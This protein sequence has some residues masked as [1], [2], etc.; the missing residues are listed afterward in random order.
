[1]SRIRQPDK[2]EEPAPAE[3]LG[4]PPGPWYDEVRDQ[5][6]VQWDQESQT[7][8]ATS[9]DAARNIARQ[10]GQMWTKVF[11]PPV[12]RDDSVQIHGGGSARNIVYADPNEQGYSDEHARLHS[13]IMRELSPARCEGLRT[14][15]VRPEAVVAVEALRNRGKAELF[16]ELAAPV[17]VRVFAAVLGLPTDERWMAEFLALDTVSNLRGHSPAPP[18]PN[19]LKAALEAARAVTE[20]LSPIVLERRDS[21]DGTLLSALWRDANEIFDPGWGTHDIIGNA[22]IMLRAGSGTTVSGTCNTLYLLL[23]QPELQEHLRSEPDDVSA[24]VEEALRYYPPVPFILR[25]AVESTTLEEVAVEQG[26]VVMIVN[27][28][29]NRDPSHYD[30][31]HV[32]DIQRA[33]ARDHFT[34]Q[35]GVRGCVGQ[36]FARIEIEEIVRAVLDL[37]P[38]GLDPDA[39]APSWGG[40]P[41]RV[42]HARWTPLHASW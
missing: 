11:L 25:A 10:D 31:P 23:T 2:A 29:A 19:E 20:M 32:F 18:E 14:S 9:Y 24:F 4:Q 42:G 39:E 38:L 28:A 30:S 7:W 22:R 3:V 5:S 34:F 17:P 26:D 35:R 12:D 41:G 37:G 15:A 40:R 6:P 13:W 27:A 33:R 16:S 1:V 8:V 36:S 21:D